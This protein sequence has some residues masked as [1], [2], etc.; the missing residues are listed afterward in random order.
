[1]YVC[2]RLYMCERERAVISD[3]NQLQPAKTCR[4]FNSNFLLNLDFASREV[5]ISHV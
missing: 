1:M 2:L 3:M 5:I 4:V